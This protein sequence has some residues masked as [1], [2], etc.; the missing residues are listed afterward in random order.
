ME[1]DSAVERLLTLKVKD[2]MTRRVVC[3]AQDQ[4][5]GEAARLLLHKGI[6]GAPVVDEQERCV[7]VLS[8]IDYVRREQELR[9]CPP[10][11][12][13]DDH[14]RDSMSTRVRSVQPE[15]TLLNAARIMCEEH[16]HRLPVLSRDGKPM[17]LITCMDVVAALVN[18]IDERETLAR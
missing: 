8:A 7:G 13:W 15:Q 12:R 17:G 3:V 18:A 14:V 11:E 2:V 10:Q 9:K 1:R 5:L 16:L 4:T 6:S